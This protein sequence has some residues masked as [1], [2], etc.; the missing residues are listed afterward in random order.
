[1]L[2]NVDAVSNCGFPRHRPQFD[3]LCT[4]LL[5]YFTGHILVYWFI[6]LVYWSHTGNSL[7]SYWSTGQLLVYW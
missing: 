4:G 6:L 5:V 1:M 3:H 7:A 2:V